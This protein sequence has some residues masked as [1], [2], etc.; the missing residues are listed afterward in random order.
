MK[1][2]KFETIDDILLNPKGALQEI[3]RL[4]IARTLLKDS[5]KQWRKMYHAKLSESR[6][7]TTRIV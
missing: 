5:C 7:Q 2:Q 6:T 3:A 4:R 1:E